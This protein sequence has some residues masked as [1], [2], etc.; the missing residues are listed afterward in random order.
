VVRKQVTE[1]YRRVAIAVDFSAQ[2]AAAM[3]E[4][5]RLAP[6]ASLELVHA[7]DIPLTFQQAMLRAGT[8]ETEIQKY[9]AARADKARED[10]SSFTREI[11]GADQAA[12]RILEGQAGPVLVRLSKSRS[13][14]LLAMG[15]HGRGIILQALLGSVTQRVLRET[16]CDVLVTSSLK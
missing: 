1:P 10:L 11:L 12:I 2:S 14:D 15:P 3:M 8:T 6:G 4:A 16:R 13:V 9:L 5:H 7:V